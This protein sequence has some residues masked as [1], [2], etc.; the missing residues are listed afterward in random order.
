MNV[1][2]GSGN[3]GGSLASEARPEPTL[4]PLMPLLPTTAASADGRDPLGGGQNALELMSGI[5]AAI[6]RA[7]TDVT[8]YSHEQM[9]GRPLTVHRDD[10]EDDVLSYQ[11]WGQ[12]AATGPRQGE[13][14]GRRS[15][16]Q[17]YPAWL[18]YR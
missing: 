14:S 6:K 4:T 10:V 13:V 11:V 9:I 12:M 5:V 2:P 17:S 7:Y 18:S 15:N 1:G 16:G 8:A 3:T